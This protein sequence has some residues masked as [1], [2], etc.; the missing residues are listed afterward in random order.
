MN[1]LTYCDEALE[2]MMIPT[3]VALLCGI[4]R[5]ERTRDSWGAQGGWYAD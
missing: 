5:E 1:Y 3:T 4:E 2:K